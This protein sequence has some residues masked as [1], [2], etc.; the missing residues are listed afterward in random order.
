[1]L[2]HHT[3]CGTSV[4]WPGIE[5]RPWKW[6]CQIQ[7]TRELPQWAI[8]AF[9]L[10]WEISFYRWFISYFKILSDFTFPKN[11]SVFSLSHF[12]YIFAEVFRKFSWCC[13]P[14]FLLNL[15]CQSF[16]IFNSSF[17]IFLSFPYK[18]KLFSH[19]R[20]W[21]HGLQPTRFLCPWNSPGKNTG[22]GCHALLHGIFPTQG[23]NPGLPR[24]RWIL[25]HPRHHNILLLFVFVK[26]LMKSS[27]S[28]LPRST[29][30]FLNYLYPQGQICYFFGLSLF[31]L[32]G[33]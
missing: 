26:I 2:A 10:F 18:W 12:P 17:S 13:L 33:M 29:A 20:L 11:W 5:P 23:S 28:C 27:P 15:L 9:F 4:P 7:T 30:Y 25:Y 24:C 14:A 21:P 6:Q 16:I 19:V 22:V 31:F 1:M 3:A 32:C 8:K